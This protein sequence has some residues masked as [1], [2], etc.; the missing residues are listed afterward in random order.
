MAPL[1]PIINTSITPI[2]SISMPLGVQGTGITYAQ[3]L[4][5]LGKSNYGAEF[6]Y[7][8]ANSY[9]QIGQPFFYTQFDANGNQIA[10]TM[11]F[12][13]DPYQSQPSIYYESDPE[14]IIFTGL[15]SLTFNSFPTSTIYLKFFATITYL[16]NELDDT[17]T[18]NFEDLEIAEGVRFFDGFCDYLLDEIQA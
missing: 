4:Q 17:Q 9:E 11:P 2:I 5:S 8:W 15:S 6:F 1:P 16:G 3:F 18:N 10:T 13:V 12:S 7:M 14:V